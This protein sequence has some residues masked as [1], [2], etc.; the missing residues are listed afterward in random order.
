MVGQSL[1]DLETVPTSSPFFLQELHRDREQVGGDRPPQHRLH[2]RWQGV[3]HAKTPS[4]VRLMF[5][6]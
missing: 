6:I 5:F 4:K 3:R 1:N 2:V